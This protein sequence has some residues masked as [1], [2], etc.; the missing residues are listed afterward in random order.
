M[1]IEGGM[2]CNYYTLYIYKRGNLQTDFILYSCFP[3]YEIMNANLILY[4]VKKKKK[5]N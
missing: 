5:K 4:E 3:L 1:N 2:Y